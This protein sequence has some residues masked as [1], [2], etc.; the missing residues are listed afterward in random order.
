M[1]YAAL[2]LLVAACDESPFGT[3]HAQPGEAI[4]GKLQADG[5]NACLVWSPPPPSSQMA[6]LGN[7]DFFYVANGNPSAPQLYAY[8]QPAPGQ[9]WQQQGNPVNAD[10][11]QIFDV[12][13]KHG[14]CPYV[15]TAHHVAP[16]PFMSG[17][18][19]TDDNNYDRGPVFFAF[20]AGDNFYYAY[21]THR[22][23]GFETVSG[24]QKSID[25]GVDAVRIALN[26]GRGEIWVA[27]QPNSSSWDML[28]FDMTT[29]KQN[30]HVQFPWPNADL[31]GMEWDDTNQQ[32]IA[33][34][35]QRIPSICEFVFTPAS[36]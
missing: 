22:E 25:P 29:L 34:A 31:A 2:I 6:G 7:G 17:N 32:L 23:L 24:Q 28:A 4:L 13:V 33:I 1:K 9:A 35:N 12:A 30:G 16:A 11:E 26:S 18:C 36:L 19:R 8:Q 20:D 21:Q 14:H 5:A 15:S 27:Y 10:F 3:R